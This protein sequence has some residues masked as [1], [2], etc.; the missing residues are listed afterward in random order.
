MAGFS[1]LSRF[2][3]ICNLFFIGAMLA[4]MFLHLDESQEL[5]TVGNIAV[6]MGMVLSPIINMSL[7]LWYL[8]ILMSKKQITVPVWVRIF[9]LIVLLAQLFFYIILP[10]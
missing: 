5:G 10:A 3:F 8:I 9:N 6:V 7:H 1:F 4:R 2:A